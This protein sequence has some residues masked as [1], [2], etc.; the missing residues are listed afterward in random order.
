MVYGG[1]IYTYYG[2]WKVFIA[3]YPQQEDLINSMAISGTDS[4]EVPTIYK[5]Y[6]QAYG[7][8]NITTKYGQKYGTNVPPF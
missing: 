5:A 6:F 2:M 7:C 1:Y 3:S 8:G 4:L